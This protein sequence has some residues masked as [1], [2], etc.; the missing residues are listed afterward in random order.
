MSVVEQGTA[1]NLPAIGGRIATTIRWVVLWTGILTGM[2][3]GDHYRLG[4]AATL[5]LGFNAR[6]LV[7]KICEIASGTVDGGISSVMSRVM[8]L[9]SVL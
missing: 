1:Y 8:L 6:G 4:F 9:T 3:G 5:A 2:A 7:D